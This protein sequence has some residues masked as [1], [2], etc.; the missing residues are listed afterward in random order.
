MLEDTARMIQQCKAEIVFLQE[1]HEKPVDSYAVRSLTKKLGKKNWKYFSTFFYSIKQSLDQDGER[2]KACPNN[3]NNAILY[4]SQKF[5]AKDLAAD[6]GFINFDGDFLFDKNNVQ[7]V[8]FCDKE[9]EKEFLCVNVHLP[10]NDT[11]HRYRDLRTLERLYAKHK[12]ER[13]VLIAGDFN[14]S[15]K[16]LTARNFDFVDGSNGWRSDRHMGLRTTL[17]AKEGDRVAFSKDYDHFIFNKKISVVRETQRFFSEQNK[18][19]CDGFYFGDAFY[20]NSVD[21]R[22]NVSDHIPIMIVLEF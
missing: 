10:Y 15:R 9:S 4:D 5:F 16:E 2:Y 13:G 3:Q 6:E 20:S 17:S 14:I 18:N 1:V 7:A 12:F 19:S 21:F 8:L 11:E 22:K